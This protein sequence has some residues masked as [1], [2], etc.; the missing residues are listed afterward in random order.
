MKWGEDKNKV[1][2]SLVYLLDEVND[3][4]LCLVAG[5]P[6]VQV[7]DHVDT[8]GAGQA[9]ST[10]CLQRGVGEGM[11][12]SGNVRGTHVLNNIAVRS[13]EGCEDER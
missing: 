8:D 6:L 2:N 7:G 13:K 5:E 1:K 12:F 10:L 4:L 3:L 11:L 9:V